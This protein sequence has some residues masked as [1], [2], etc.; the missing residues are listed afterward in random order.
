ME[1]MFHFGDLPIPDALQDVLHTALEL[2]R[3]DYMKAAKIYA[4]KVQ[5]GAAQRV[6]LPTPWSD[7]HH[8][9]VVNWLLQ[10]NGRNGL[11]CQYQQTVQRR[12]LLDAYEISIGGISEA[13]I[14][15]ATSIESELRGM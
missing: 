10:G 2:R 6:V 15:L 7:D 3:C 9:Q 8:F 5:C 4:D 11:S 14:T 12:A 13:D 1:D